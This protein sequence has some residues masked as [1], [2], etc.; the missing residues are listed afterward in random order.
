[1]I[2]KDAIEHPF[3]GDMASQSKERTQLFKAV[4]FGKFHQNEQTLSSNVQFMFGIVNILI[5]LHNLHKLDFCHM[6]V[7][8]YV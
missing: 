8:L 3:G 7:M 5:L 6:T 1:M 4:V 2:Q